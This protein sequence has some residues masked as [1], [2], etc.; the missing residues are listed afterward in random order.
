VAGTQGSLEERRE[1]ESS[2]SRHWP[3]SGVGLNGV[4]PLS[5]WESGRMELVKGNDFGNDFA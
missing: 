4:S 3:C 2:A 1:L 5:I